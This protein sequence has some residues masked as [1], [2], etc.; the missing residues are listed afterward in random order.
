M[1]TCYT[2]LFYWLPTYRKKKFVP[3]KIY[4]TVASRLSKKVGKVPIL[5]NEMKCCSCLFYYLSELCLIFFL[6]LSLCFINCLHYQ[7]IYILYIYIKPF[8]PGW[9]IGKKQIF[10]IRFCLS[11]YTPSLPQIYWSPSAW[12][13]SKFLLVVRSSFSLLGSSRVLFYISLCRLFLTCAPSIPI[14]FS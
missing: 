8:I 1:Y 12:I 6:C 14:S 13:S 3:R 10:S 5:T 7:I 4:L 9:D 2:Q 11:Q